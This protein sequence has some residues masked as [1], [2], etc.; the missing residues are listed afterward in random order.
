MAQGRANSRNGNE[1]VWGLAAPG[2]R[3]KRQMKFSLLWESMGSFCILAV[4][5]DISATRARIHTKYY[6]YRDNVCRRAPSPCGVHRPLEGG[7]RGHVSRHCPYINNIW[8]RSVHALL[9]YRSKTAKMQKFPIDS[10]SNENFICLFFRPPGP[11][12]PKLPRS[13]FWSLLYPEPKFHADRT[14][15]R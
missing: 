9:R 3:K 13:R 10:H 15:L 4:L 5:S 6:L 1:V 8:C 14:I 11:P 12:T 7:G 2:G